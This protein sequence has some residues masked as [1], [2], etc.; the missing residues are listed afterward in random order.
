M[1][2][3]P[4]GIKLRRRL[5]DR[6]ATLGALLMIILVLAPLTAIFGYLVFRGLGA[7]NWEFLV[8]TPRPVGE[9]GGGMANAIVGSGLIL[10]IAC[11]IGI[12]L[13]VGAG[14]YLAEYARGR[15]GDLVRFTAD[16]LNGVPS[17]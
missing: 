15:F 3:N 5:A 6:A 9:T 7:L 2:N 11:L 8:H 1:P 12:P 10:G 16:V 13:G 4:Q 14:I 17:I